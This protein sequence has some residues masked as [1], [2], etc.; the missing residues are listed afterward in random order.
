VQVFNNNPLECNTF[1]YISN[2][3]ALIVDAGS[4]ADE[5]LIQLKE[6][7]I[8]RVVLAYTHFHFDHIAYGQ[9][10]TAAITKLDIA[11][12]TIANKAEESFFGEAGSQYLTAALQ[13]FNLTNYYPADK[14]PIINNFLTNNQ[15]LDVD[16]FI[17]LATPG[18]SIGSSCY[19]SKNHR[20]LFSGDTIFNHGAVGRYD[21]PTS[22]IG[23]LKASIARLITLP[24][25]TIVYPGHGSSYRLA[26]QKANFEH[27]LARN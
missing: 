19:Y 7:N 11:L 17:L 4:P 5:V 22:N 21:L 20:I 2:N 26:E 10:Y 24:D 25:D 16:D 6:H 3:A 13:N 18:H 27:Y 15:P 14:P 8:K 23:Q 12:T 1:L 9:S